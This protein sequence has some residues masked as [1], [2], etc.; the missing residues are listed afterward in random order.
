MFCSLLSSCSWI[1]LCCVFLVGMVWFELGGC[2]CWYVCIAISSVLLLFVLWYGSLVVLVGFCCLHV[3]LEHLKVNRQALDHTKL[4]NTFTVVRSS[5]KPDSIPLC[6][7]LRKGCWETLDFQQGQS[8]KCDNLEM[9]WRL[10]TVLWIHLAP[11]GQTKWKLL[12][13]QMHC[14]NVGKEG[15]PINRL[16]AFPDIQEYA[17]HGREQILSG[18]QHAARWKL[19]PFQWPLFRSNAASPSA[20]QPYMSCLVS[21]CAGPSVL[22]LSWNLSLRVV[23]WIS[24][25]GQ[26]RP[27]CVGGPLSEQAVR[28]RPGIMSVCMPNGCS[29][30]L[31]WAST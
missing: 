29:T 13:G 4:N 23:H 24:I 18:L 10:L 2:C 3:L 11:L 9:L 27:C 7:L 15:L 30:I 12:G 14:P 17:C 25:G 16:V 6:Y 28:D 22:D 21:V 19:W 5:T 26:G 1:V 20:R 31:C 8:W